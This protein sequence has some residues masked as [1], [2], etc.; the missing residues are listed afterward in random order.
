M[1][2]QKRFV[3]Q[4]HLSIYKYFL[5]QYLYT[6]FPFRTCL[7]HLCY[8]NKTKHN[9]MQSSGYKTDH[10]KQVPAVIIQSLPLFPVFIRHVKSTFQVSLCDISSRASSHTVLTGEQA[11]LK[12]MLLCMENTGV[13][14]IHPVQIKV[15]SSS[16]GFCC[17]QIWPDVLY[18]NTCSTQ[19]PH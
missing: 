8:R 6:Y 1:L 17:K 11:L 3:R 13:N 7:F 9:S 16:K 10:I 14:K 19:F 18:G 5:F 12:H 4:Q 2:G 15:C